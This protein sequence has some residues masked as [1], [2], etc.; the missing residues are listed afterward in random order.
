MSA[1]VVCE[2]SPGGRRAIPPHRVQLPE[3]SFIRDFIAGW[4]AGSLCWG[5]VVLVELARAWWP[6]G[7][8]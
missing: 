1:L 3:S 4:I 8:L 2:L 5:P 7:G 6:G